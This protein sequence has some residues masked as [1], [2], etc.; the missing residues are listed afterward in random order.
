[1]VLAITI[2]IALQNLI[3]FGVSMMDT[4]MLGRLGNIQLSASAQANQPGFVFQLF[5]FGLAG[6]G[7]VLAAQ[8]WG[9]RDMEA[10]RRIFAIVIRFSAVVGILL[11]VLAL[12]FPEE[13]MSFY[14]KKDTAEDMLI[15]SEAVKY[16]K[17]IAYSYLFFGLSLCI[18][19]LFR[20]IE[21]VKI[22]VVTSSISFC[23]NVFL[24]W[25]F[26]F[27]NL[28]APKMGISGAALATSIARGFECLVIL[29][30]LFVIDKKLKFRI[31]YVFRRDKQLFRDYIRYSLPVVGNELLWST[32][33]TLQAAILGKLSS[34][35]L[36]ANSIAMVLQQLAT[37][38]TFGV[39]SA[40]AVL[41]GKRI[42][43]GDVEG[44]RSTASTIMIWSVILGL[45]GSVLIFVLRKPFV[46]IYN[47]E[48][49]IKL[50]AQ[51]LLIITSV[52][53]FFISISSNSIV[54]VLRGAGDTKFSFKLELIALWFVAIP[55]GFCAGY[56]LKLPVLVAYAFLKIDEPIKSIIAY[57]RT[58]K[59]KTYKSVTRD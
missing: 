33:V 39:S 5:N 12:M 30:Y 25:V 14:I 10:I 9:K 28:G 18:T 29:F 56:I 58:T 41:V 43:E 1:M 24:N 48:P 47:I 6:G 31:S 20:S 8:Y 45:L 15:L 36:A 37:L 7:T 57:I 54:G 38:I 3:V 26:I 51:N 4:I 17:I 22:S 32:G 27:G 23:I 19:F 46:S 53:V 16:L 52:I 50:M 49:R 59:A 55:L 21:I 35:I 2:P 40:A 44:A 34:D 42:G 13:I 11:S